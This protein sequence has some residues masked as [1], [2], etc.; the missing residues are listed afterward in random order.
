VCLASH[1]GLSAEIGEVGDRAFGPGGS[2]ELAA[3][4]N[5]LHRLSTCLFLLVG[6]GVLGL[7]GL[8]ARADARDAGR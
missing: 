4:F 7:V 2:Q 5:R 6:L 1:F 3:R 8:H